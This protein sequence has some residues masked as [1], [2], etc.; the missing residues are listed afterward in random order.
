[1]RD[2]LWRYFSKTG[3]ID[4]Y[5]LYKRQETMTAKSMLDSR[6]SSKPYVEDGFEEDEERPTEPYS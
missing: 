5:L 4:A 6:A 3:E 1:M 2:F